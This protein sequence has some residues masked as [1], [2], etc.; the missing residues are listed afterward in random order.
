MGAALL[1]L[2]A[3][4]GGPERLVHLR[5]PPDASE[6]ECCE[7]WRA[8]IDA[9]SRAQ[10]AVVARLLCARPRARR[11][12]L[13]VHLMHGQSNRLLVLIWERDV[14][15]S[16]RLEDLLELPR[17]FPPAGEP[18]FAVL[19][20]ADDSLFPPSVFR[21]YNY[22]GTPEARAERG[23]AQGSVQAQDNGSAARLREGG[24][25]SDVLASLIRAA[26][27]QSAI[28]VHLGMLV[29]M[30]RDVP[31]IEGVA[32]AE[33]G[34]PL[35]FEA[36]PYRQACHWR[37]FASAME[38]VCG[39]APSCTF[40]VAADDVV[41]IRALR[42]HFAR[43]AHAVLSL[44]EGVALADQLTLARESRYVLTS[45][46]S[47]FSELVLLWSPWL[48]KHSRSGCAPVQRRPL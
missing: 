47:S 45:T 29:D 21:R 43:T 37:A 46:W 41:A 48:L 22:M 16:A 33:R 13:V 20:F 42:T 30:R 24:K 26:R 38:A 31:G 19:D 7:R 34:L 8:E 32:D 36:I 27:N 15:C 5:P 18:S 14:H 1:W 11:M 6:R 2:S 10:I 40:Y 12:T 25:L 23:G 9:C 35:M 28:G 4:A 3:L 44:F 39:G 17:A